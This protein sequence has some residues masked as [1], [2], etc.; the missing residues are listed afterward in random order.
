V[1]THLAGKSL[2]DVSGSAGIVKVTI[3]DYAPRAQLFTRNPA[4]PR[5]NVV[6]SLRPRLRLRNSV[7]SPISSGHARRQHAQ[8]SSRHVRSPTLPR[9]N[10]CPLRVGT[11]QPLGFGHRS[12]LAEHEINDPAPA[13]VWAFAATVAQ[14]VLV[15]ASGILKCVGQNGHRGEVAAFV[16]LLRE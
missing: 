8:A 5:G 11:G 2:K 4:M 3:R 15:V 7:R 6:R 12:L 13:D 16:H 14:H 9:R 10:C 1:R